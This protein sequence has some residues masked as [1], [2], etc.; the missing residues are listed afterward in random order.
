MKK[1]LLTI[2]FLQLIFASLLLAGTKG[3]IAGRVV[4]AETGAP[5][6]GVNVLI[7]GTHLGAATDMQGDYRILNVPPGIY[8]VIARMMGYEVQ[9]KTEVLV[10]SDRTIK[11]DFGLKMG[12]VEGEVVTIV[13]EKEVVAMDMSSSVVSIKADELETMPQV[14]DVSDFVNLQAGVDGWNIRGGDAS[15]TQFMMDGL[16]MVDN[17]ANQII[18]QPNLSSVEEINILKGGFD[19]EYGNVRSGVISV[20]TKKGDRHK[21]HGSLDYQHVPAYQKHFGAAINDADNYYLKPFLDETNDLCWL[22][23]DILPDD[24]RERYPAFMGWNAFAEDM[25]YGT[26][27]D[28]QKVFIWERR[29]PGAN[30]LTPDNYQGKG[31]R[32]FSYGDKPDMMLD[33]G[34]GGPVPGMGDKMTFFGS[35]R[36]NREAYAL[37]T[38][39]DYF[40]DQNAQLKLNYYLK[41]EMELEV[42]AVLGETNTMARNVSGGV[43]NSYLG[44]GMDM[45][46]SSLTAGSGDRNSG[47]LYLPSALAPYDI[48]RNILGATFTHAVN[49][50]TYYTLRLTRSSIENKSDTSWYDMRS[51]MTYNLKGVDPLITVDE[52]PYGLVTENLGSIDG[53]MNMGG[54]QASQR[55]FSK[56]TTTNFKFDMTSQVNKHNQVK[57]GVEMNYDDNHTIVGSDELYTKSL[58]FNDEWKSKAYRGA[59]YVQDKIEYE[60]MIAKLG[61]RM[62]YFNPNTDWF[63]EIYSEYFTVNNKTNLD[64]AAK[65]AADTQVYLSPRFG[66]SHPIS[67]KAKLYFN[68]GHFYSLPLTRE[69]FGIGLG[70]PIY[71]VGYVGNPNLKMEKT[72]AYELGFDFDILGQYL[73]HVA[74]YY[75][76]N[77]DQVGGVR[78]HGFDDRVNYGT[79]AN[80]NYEDVRGFEI[81]LRKRYGRWFTGWVNYDYRVQTSGHVGRYEYYQDL[82]LQQA[83]GMYELLEDQ[84]DTRPAARANATLHIPKDYGPYMGGWAFSL[85]FSYRDGPR[86]SWHP[87]QNKR[88]LPEYQNNVEWKDYYMF[89]ARFSKTFQVMGQKVEFY[90][91]VNNLFNIKHLAFGSR[92]FADT[93]DWEKYMKSLH[94]PMYKGDD[95][96]EYEGGSDTP[97]DV[98]GSGKDYVNMPNRG[99][100]TYTNPRAITVGLRYKF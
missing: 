63:S 67:E 36:L 40:K 16:M 41:P 100:L 98:K 60:G 79:Q 9:K 23:T 24:E 2:I 29:L 97:G 34:F 6:V 5:L 96:S 93:G 49:P 39:R 38:Y 31:P 19:A 1:G 71:P 58:G 33:A 83:S 52:R 21:Y 53:E 28:W 65:K 66:I 77:T 11:V 84:S 57:F 14:R 92:G 30:K 89:D 78:Y 74:G 17:R 15:E 91:M 48:K 35:Y 61:L 82:R 12:Y 88:Q 7:E 20:V 13:A 25:G 44:S 10:S 4:D 46:W 86:I 73:L 69:L 37:P 59:A 22:G 45:M 3:K 85:L 51:A 81:Q 68:Y 56:T 87:D 62:D 18:A 80:N 42:S 54:I 50:E 64:E 43:R 99:F 27:E 47:S 8:N 95:F 72:I 26:A 76:D 94:L 55:D 75:R 32:E 70:G 90:G